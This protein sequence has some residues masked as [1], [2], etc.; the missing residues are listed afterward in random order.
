V[1]AV[2]RHAEGEGRGVLA[3]VVALVLQLVGGLGEGD[4]R[5]QRACALG[6]G[7]VAWVSHFGWFGDEIAVVDVGFGPPAIA[8]CAAALRETEDARGCWGGLL[9]YVGGAWCASAM[10]SLVWGCG[11]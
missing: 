4:A 11:C 1:V 6:L 7:D 9:R 8:G 5:V 2:Q 10:G 3:G